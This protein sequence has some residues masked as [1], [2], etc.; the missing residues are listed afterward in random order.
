MN[1]FPRL[2]RVYFTGRACRVRAALLAAL[3]VFG[4][5]S[6]GAAQTRGRG[7][8]KAP[9]P[10]VPA[11]V[12]FAVGERLDYAVQWNRTLTAATV[13]LAVTERREFFGNQAWHFQATA[14][15]IDPLRRIV[16]LDDQFDSY[17]D[18]ITLESH[19]YESYLREQE[20][21]DDL[22]VPMATQSQPG[23]A[24]RRVFVVFPGTTD[25]LGMIYRLRP[26]DWKNTPEAHLRLFDGRKFYDIEARREALGTPVTVAA[27]T[28][29]ATR[30][31]L[32]ILQDGVE[33]PNLK[34]W[35]S[36]SE[37]AART[38]VLIEAEASIGTVRAELTAHVP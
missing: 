20:K 4:T 21:R 17:T 13:R 5:A 28:F 18:T 3:A 8:K 36:L 24:N 7:K 37:D 1:R 9:A 35:I 38:P 32:R 6:L 16:T 11:A 14:Q 10:P 25:P 19:Q 30:I 31:A 27:G 23:S 2:P 34:L 29:A 22:V 33:M 26:L 12:P 15:T